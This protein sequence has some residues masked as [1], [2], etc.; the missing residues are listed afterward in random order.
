[1]GYD[2]CVYFYLSFIIKGQERFVSY[3]QARYPVSMRYKELLGAYTLLSLPNPIQFLP[4]IKA[5]LWCMTC[6]MHVNLH[7]ISI[8]L[9]EI[10][11][12]FTVCTVIFTDTSLEWNS[13]VWIYPK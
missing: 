5:V 6:T 12:H 11:S 9:P 2:V 4:G 3:H 10:C 8:Y 1:M 13:R 7:M